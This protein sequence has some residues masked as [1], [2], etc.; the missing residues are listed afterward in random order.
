MASSQFPLV[1]PPPGPF[2]VVVVGYNSRLVL[3]G[4][5]REGTGLA[6]RLHRR[7]HKRRRHLDARKGACEIG[8][9]V[10]A[11]EGEPRARGDARERGARAHVGTEL[12]ERA[13]HRSGRGAVSPPSEAGDGCDDGDADD[14]D[15]GDAA[16]TAAPGDEAAS[17]EADDDDA[18]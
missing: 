16:A 9:A 4:C 17:D 1:S 10:G 7:E 15:R 11:N 13:R 5:Q 12:L 18:R 6:T 8:V 3:R 2:V 14:A